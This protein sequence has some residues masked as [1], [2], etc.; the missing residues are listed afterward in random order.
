MWSWV[1]FFYIMGWVIA[2]I[3]G[4]LYKIIPFL[5]WTYKYS[6]RIGKEKVPT[7][8]EM[9]NEKASVI[10]F[11]LFIISIIGLT[12][13][14]LYSIGIVVFLFQGLLTITSVLYAISVLKI[15]FI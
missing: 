13:G 8:K 11:T 14:G 9:I 6:E 2:S 15:F 4:Y 5:W 10:L 1:V 7:L 12:I 3:L